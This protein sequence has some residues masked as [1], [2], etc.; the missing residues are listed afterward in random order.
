MAGRGG[1]G[2]GLV[3]VEG[4]GEG[5]GDD[6]LAGKRAGGTGVG[7]KGVC[8][9]RAGEE[10]RGLWARSPECHNDRAEALMTYR[11]TAHAC[12]H[13]RTAPFR[14]SHLAVPVREN[15]RE[16]ERE[17][18]KERERE[19]ARERE[20]ERNLGRPCPPRLRHLLLHV[21][22]SPPPRRPPP[23]PQQVPLSLYIE[24]LSLFESVDPS[25]SESTLGST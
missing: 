17:R 1:E 10:G 22:L 24:T 15:E 8:V 23:P 2:L 3:G 13:A 5:V 25:P 16:R 6:G 14:H 7:G 12:T 4:G 20:R 9:R 11:R 21:P 19:R 18:E